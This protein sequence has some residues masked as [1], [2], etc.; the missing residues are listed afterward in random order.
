MKAVK[1]INQNRRSWLKNGLVGLSYPVLAGVGGLAMV[2]A[3]AQALEVV[4]KPETSEQE[5]KIRWKPYDAPGVQRIA[6]ERDAT[7]VV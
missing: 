5:T 2:N 1:H 7:E 4:K 3:E 6:R